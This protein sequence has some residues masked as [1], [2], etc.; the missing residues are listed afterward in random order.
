MRALVLCEHDQP[1][2]AVNRLLFISAMAAPPSPTPLSLD[3]QKRQQDLKDFL[4]ILADEDS[5]DAF[6][7]RV[8]CVCFNADIHLGLPRSNERQ[9]KSVFL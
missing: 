5:C 6:R 3:V 8:R 4:D 2:A 7:V 1:A 9:R